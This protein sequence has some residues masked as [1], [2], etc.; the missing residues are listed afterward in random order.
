MPHI[1]KLQQE[2]KGKVT[3][4]GVDVWEKVPEGKPYGSAVP[5]VEKFVKGND[6]NMGY[7]VSVD[8]DEQ[9]MGNN[10]L[11]A[12]GENGIP[13]TFIVKGNKVIWIGHP[14]SLDSTL[15]KILNGTY[16]MEEFAARF[17]KRADQSRKQR[18]K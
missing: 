10:W 5:M 15:P 9:F 16:N 1:S 6:A 4:I 2:Y 3:F 7:S 12:A 14:N 8:D 11:K 18:E 13:S 17:N